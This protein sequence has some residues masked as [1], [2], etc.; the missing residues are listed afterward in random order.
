MK[1]IML[2]L[3]TMILSGCAS[4][5]DSGPDQVI[6]GRH[7][8]RKP[9]FQTPS[10]EPTQAEPT[11]QIDYTCMDNCTSS[12]YMRGLCESKCSY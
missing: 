1:T 9:I 8:N 6:T 7:H 4:M 5:P 12:G 3:L 2:V 10:R 11:K